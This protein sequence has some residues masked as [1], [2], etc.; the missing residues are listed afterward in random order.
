MVWRQ[1]HLA[2]TLR[3]FWHVGDVWIAQYRNTLKSVI[4]FGGP[5]GIRTLDLR[6]S[7]AASGAL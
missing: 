7:D 3:G 4:G 5:G 2:L 6:R 1:G